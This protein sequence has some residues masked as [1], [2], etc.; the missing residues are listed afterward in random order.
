ML[1]VLRDSIDTQID[2]G[3]VT[4]IQNH[5]LRGSSDLMV[6]TP[7]TRQYYSVLLAR[8]YLGKSTA[9]ISA[10]LTPNRRGHCSPHQPWLTRSFSRAPVQIHLVVVALPRLATNRIFTLTC[11]L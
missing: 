1:I 6:D 10:G 11:G 8:R 3:A 5:H 2:C 7:H 4:L 9:C